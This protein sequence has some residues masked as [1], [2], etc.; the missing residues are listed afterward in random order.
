MK[1]FKDEEGRPWRLALTSTTASRV[2]DLVSV[3][4]VDE[5]SGERRSI[6]F[7]IVDIGTIT[8]TFQTIRS[9]FL[10]LSEI[11]YAML[12][13]QIEERKLTKDQFMD[14]LRGDSLEAAAKA[15]ESELIDF[16]PQRLRPMVA[17]LA[18]K[19]DEVS[20]EVMGQ[21]EAVLEKLT[22]ADLSGTPSG[23]A[24]E[25]SESTQASGR[26]GNSS[27]RGKHASSMIGGTPQT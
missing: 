27:R 6:P 26:S 23:S 3:E 7:D 10:K 24:P 12:L 18:R 16:F 5:E 21:A 17:L 22:A 1:E 8:Q 20:A 9:Q 25:S 11:L 19:M 2:R 4:V 13:P 15:L 14:G